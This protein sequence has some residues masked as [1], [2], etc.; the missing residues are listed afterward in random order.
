MPLRLPSSQNSSILIFLLPPLKLRFQLDFHRVCSRP[1]LPRINTSAAA[2]RITNVEWNRDFSF[3][4]SYLTTIDRR[5]G[6]GIPENA[7]RVITAVKRSCCSDWRPTT[8]A[9]VRFRGESYVVVEAGIGQSP[10]CKRLYRANAIH[11][12]I[13]RVSARVICRLHFSRTNQ[14]LPARLSILDLSNHGENPFLTINS[15][16]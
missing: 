13:K 6:G 2:I 11:G 5:G 1:P 4:F 8:K 9:F 10:R 3:S 14:P 12:P 15:T 16:N 7:V